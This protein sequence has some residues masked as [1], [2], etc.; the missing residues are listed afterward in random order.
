L[1]KELARKHPPIGG[2]LDG[3]YI[4][5]EDAKKKNPLRSEM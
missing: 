3:Y 4:L 2:E 1:H 5:L